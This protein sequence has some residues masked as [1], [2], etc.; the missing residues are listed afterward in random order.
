[1]DK[2]KRTFITDFMAHASDADPEAALILKDTL[3]LIW[4]EFY[5]EYEWVSI[6]DLD[7]RYSKFVTT[8]TSC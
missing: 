7:D 8:E 5:E 2:F 4:K 1:M 3:S 6:D